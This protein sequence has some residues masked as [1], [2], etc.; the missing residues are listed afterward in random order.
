MSSVTWKAQP[1][2][3]PNLRRRVTSDLGAPTHVL[4]HLLADG[5]AFGFEIGDLAADHAV[6]GTGGG[7]DF[8]EH[9]DA[10]LGVNRSGADNFESKSEESVAGENGGGFA[11]FFVASG[12]AATKIVVIE[13][14]K[15][16]MNERVGV[17]EF[18][19]AS[20]MESGGDVGFEDARGFQQ[21][22]RADTLAAG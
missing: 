8:G 2:F 18:D 19:R 4:E 12:F 7:S 21:Q 15:I 6:D 14:G 1:M 20:G 11:E 3:S 9:G 22:D 5:F 10:A 16:V 13:R 17:D